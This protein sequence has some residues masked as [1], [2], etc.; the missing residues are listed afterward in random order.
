MPIYEFI[1][2]DCGT[3]FEKLVS[4]SSTVAPTCVSCQSEN[5]KRQMGLPAVHFKGSGWY[6]TDSKK[7]TDSKKEW[8]WCCAGK[9]RKER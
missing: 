6:I 3:E 9:R 2:N 8:K 1:C 5:V 7:S 4:F